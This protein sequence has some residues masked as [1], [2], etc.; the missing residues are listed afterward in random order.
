MAFEKLIILCLLSAVFQNLSNAELHSN[1][2]GIEKILERCERL[3]TKFEFLIERDIETDVAD[4]KRLVTAHTEDITNLRINQGFLLETVEEQESQISGLQDNVL[5]NKNQVASHKE[6]LDNHQISIDSRS[7]SIL[8]HENLLNSHTT[9]IQSNLD[10]VN[11]NAAKIEEDRININKNLA[12]I[13]SLTE[14][15]SS[16]QN[17][18][19]RFHVESVCCQGYSAWPDNS[20]ITFEY[21][22]LDTHNTHDGFYFTAPMSGAYGFVF[23][24]DIRLYHEH[25]SPAWI[26]MRVNDAVVKNYYFDMDE[27][28]SSD[29]PSSLF[30]LIKLNQ[31][32]RVDLVTSDSPT[33]D[34]IRNGASL[35]GFL[36]QKI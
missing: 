6:Q 32:D 26:Y 9:Q 3:T 15:F 18:L 8:S 20:R 34:I 25:S 24:A 21:K 4:L 36:L 7:A 31:G 16:F 2:L 5:Q 29:H 1:E 10:G 35:F 23:T 33:F 11:S 14:S 12:D 17:S 30:F 27:S 28:K 13:A 22:F 19:V